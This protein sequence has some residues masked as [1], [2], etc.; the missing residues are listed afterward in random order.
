MLGTLFASLFVA[1]AIRF[2][3]LKDQKKKSMIQNISFRSDQESAPEKNGQIDYTIP[4]AEHQSNK[5]KDET[6]I[7]MESL[8]KKKS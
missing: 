8:E 5:E 3:Q 1:A 2:L 6:V 4:E 7:R